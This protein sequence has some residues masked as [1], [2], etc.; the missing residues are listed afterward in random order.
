[1]RLSRAVATIVK[2]ASRPF[3]RPE[4]I[5]KLPSRAG[6]LSHYIANTGGTQPANRSDPAD[7]I[8][9]DYAS[10]FTPYLDPG[11]RMLW[12]GQPPQ[13]MGGMNAPFSPC[14]MHAATTVETTRNP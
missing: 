4:N 9:P 6:L 3:R 5:E 12:F 10:A 1:M 13:A 14:T 8:N 11:E 7:K 2:W